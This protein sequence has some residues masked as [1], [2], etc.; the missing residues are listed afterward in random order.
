MDWGA[1]GDLIVIQIVSTDQIKEQE[2]E[3]SPGVKKSVRYLYFSV[4]GASGR[5]ELADG[6]EIPLDYSG[7]AFCRARSHISNHTSKSGFAWSSLEY[8]PVQL[9]Y[10]IPKAPVERFN[11]NSFHSAFFGESSDS[12]R[13]K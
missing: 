5:I 7:T 11:F 6:I 9:I 2:K 13:T 3:I 10:F 8:I 4:A 12:S 1:H